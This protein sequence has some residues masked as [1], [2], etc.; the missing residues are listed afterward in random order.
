MNI[1]QHSG[2]GPPMKSYAANALNTTLAPSIA[3]KTSNSSNHFSK[4]NE[5]GY[6]KVAITAFMN[7]KA[8]S[9]T[10][11][12]SSPSL[13]ILSSS[14]SVSSSSCTPS[15]N[16]NSACKSVC[17]GASMTS[18]TMNINNIPS[19]SNGNGSGSS[20]SGGKITN[21][22][23]GPPPLPP[24]V[25][26]TTSSDRLVTGPSCKALRTAVSALYSVDDFVK[27][28]IGSGF[29]S[30]VYKYPLRKKVELDIGVVSLTR[31]ERRTGELESALS[32]DIGSIY[33]GP[34]AGRR[35]EYNSQSNA[36]S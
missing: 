17:E 24:A 10:S 11:S 19:S 15:I 13:S 16:G 28:K 2:P 34:N 22:F 31:A 35:L 14:C 27:E 9:S 30:E 12:M 21:G 6:K 29:F 4:L 32:L 33:Y 18:A 3:I 5:I 7:T 23:I 36:N 8:G 1:N 20:N 26:C 25:G